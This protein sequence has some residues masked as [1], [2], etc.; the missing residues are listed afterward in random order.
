M[1]R[2]SLKNIPLNRLV[3]TASTLAILGSGISLDKMKSNE[4]VIEFVGKPIHLKSPD[5]IDKSNKIE[6]DRCDLWIPFVGSK[7]QG[8]IRVVAQKLSDFDGRNESDA[9]KIKRLEMKIKD[10]PDR[11]MIVYKESQFNE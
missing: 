7:K 2:F 5:L 3:I 6:S 8:Q 9:W 4:A 10:L 1:N 11:L